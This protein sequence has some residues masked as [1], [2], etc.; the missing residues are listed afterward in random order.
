VGLTAPPRNNPLLRKSKE[1]KILLRKAM[2]HRGLSCQM[3]MM[4]MILSG[5][6]QDE[7]MRWARLVTHTGEIRS[8]LN[9]IWKIPVSL[10]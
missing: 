5:Y 4:M 6:S 1:V 8:V 7:N 9:Y 2:A 3:M 10:C